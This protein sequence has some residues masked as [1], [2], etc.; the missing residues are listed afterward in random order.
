[1]LRKK[2]NILTIAL[3]ICLSLTLSAFPNLSYGAA[4]GDVEGHW[5]QT[6][7]DTIQPLGVIAGY[8]NGTFKPN[9]NITRIEFVAITVNALKL[10]VRSVNA[11]EYWGAPFAEVALSAGLIG[12]D[13]YGGITEKNLNQNISR[14]EMAS[15]IV[16]AFYSRGKT[17]TETQKQ[18]ALQTLT[19]FDTVSSQYYDQS[20][21][22][23]ALGIIGGFPNSTFGPKENASRAQAAVVSYKL[24]VE[25]GIITTTTDDPSLTQ[26]TAFAVNNIE[27]GDS[28][29]WVIKKYGQPVRED[30]SEYGFKWLVY[31]NNYK[32]YYQVGIQN[33]KVVALYTS[34]DL[35]KSK[36]GFAIDFTKSKTTALLGEPLKFIQKGNVQYLQYNS[37]ETATYLSNNAYITAYFDTADAGKLF[38]VKIIDY[39]VEQSLKSQYGTASTPL[40]I[41]YEKTIFDLA[42]VFRVAHD[43]DILKWHEPLADV[44]RKHSQDMSDRSFFSHTN[45]SGY[46]PFDRILADGI[47][48]HYAAEN[49][50]AGYTSAFSAHSGW[51]NSPG[52]RDNLLRSIEYLGVGVY[53]GGE[54]VNYFT[55]DFITP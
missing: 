6:Y 33:G 42:N 10:S 53:I 22:S 19:D 12:E 7:I 11:N 55:Q 26:T 35:L 4:F 20:V 18:A 36:N 29:E 43:Q 21:A 49:I 44:A 8:P 15:I 27:I 1:M 52:H 46:T 37:D 31:H 50:A 23:V 9:S 25:L 45:P 24:L 38:S 54:F 34:S 17:V 47:D 32:N 14:E 2:N 16:N 30:I 3:V 40:R 5:A 51:V 28:Y 41:S 48:Y 13:E 39:N